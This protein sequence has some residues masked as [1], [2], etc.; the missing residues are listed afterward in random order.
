MKNKR[1]FLVIAG[2]M[3]LLLALPQGAAA[4]VERPKWKTKTAEGA[5][6]S[7]GTIREMTSQIFKARVIDYTIYRN[8]WEFSGMRPAVIYFYATWC[9]PCKRMSKTV[10]D[11][12]MKYGKQIDFYQVDI[13]VQTDLAADLGVRSAPVVLFV[14]KW[15]KSNFH[16]GMLKEKQFEH[17]LQ[18]LLIKK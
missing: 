18:Q 7:A 14:P 15:G 1:I 16:K 4:Q 5:E 6:W 10:E 9:G 8:N 11:A 13:D 2:L 17:S 12:A 3:C